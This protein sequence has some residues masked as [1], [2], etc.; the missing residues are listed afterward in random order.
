MKA[1]QIAL[2]VSAFA[3]RAAFAAI[4]SSAPGQCIRLP[5]W[6]TNPA[7]TLRAD[8]MPILSSNASPRIGRSTALNYMAI[9]DGALERWMRPRTAD[10]YTNYWGRVQPVGVSPDFLAEATVA[11]GRVYTND[12]RRM[13]TRYRQKAIDVVGEWKNWPGSY[14]GDVYCVDY[15]TTLSAYESGGEELDPTP[16]PAGTSARLDSRRDYV[17]Y[18]NL[19]SDD[20]AEVSVWAATND[21][22]LGIAEFPWYGETNATRAAVN[23]LGHNCAM[24][25]RYDLPVPYTITNRNAHKAE[26]NFAAL[27]GRAGGIMF[28]SEVSFTNSWALRP[29]N[30]IELPYASETLAA[31]DKTYHSSGGYVFRPDSFNVIC[32]GKHKAVFSS[33][34]VSIRDYR[35]VDTNTYAFVDCK[36]R[37][38]SPDMDKNPWP[39]ETTTNVTH[40]TVL[41]EGNNGSFGAGAEFEHR[42]FGYVTLLYR[43]TT[44]QPP[45]KLK[46]DFSAGDLLSVSLLAPTFN[47]DNPN[48]QPF[49]W[50]VYD[51]DDGTSA[52]YD[53]ARQSEFPI[54]IPLDDYEGEFYYELRTG[55]YGAS[56]GY[57]VPIV[58]MIPPG[59]DGSVVGNVGYSA[60]HH[61][62]TGFVSSVGAQWSA[63]YSWGDGST[64]WDARGDP[65]YDTYSAGY[66]SADTFDSLN[67]RTYAHCVGLLDGLKQEV[68][69]ST[70]VYNL[71]DPLLV[72]EGIA[73]NKCN[74]YLSELRNE[75]NTC[76]AHFD[77]FDGYAIIDDHGD[78]TLYNED[79]EEWP[80]KG[81]EYVTMVYKIVT[82]FG[83]DAGEEDEWGYSSFSAS[84]FLGFSPIIRWKWA[85][86]PLVK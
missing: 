80:K 31:I 84:C 38:P 78:V 37:I 9:F 72:L 77:L 11:N 52:S 46:G 25:T 47:P 82:V 2:L 59:S 83:G 35:F 76:D 54:H 33:D 61:S 3:V 65:A 29:T 74:G 71:D 5:D 51:C 62:Q 53:D 28:N 86:L 75:W 40:D 45:P 55:E 8:Q 7:E 50:Y 73:R 15:G 81:G 18:E 70:G 27:S 13:P 22:W 49:E 67:A 21:L 14:F 66:L 24:V 57:S 41:I 26:N 16:C 79:M 17:E 34:G 56:V 20:A 36:F 60:V 44:L 12:W 64:H 39:T 43:D 58:G 23:P 10:S 30:P 68:M 32:E 63:H 1:T 42:D 6:T 69:R 19:S 48:P 4:G 85:N